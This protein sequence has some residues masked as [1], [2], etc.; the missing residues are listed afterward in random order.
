MLGMTGLLGLVS[1]ALL[2]LRGLRVSR[3]CR[4]LLD[5]RALRALTPLCR[6]L[7]GLLVLTALPALLV[8][9]GL[10]GVRS[11]TRNADPTVGGLSHGLTGPP[12]T[13]ANAALI[14]HPR[15]ELRHDLAC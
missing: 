3:A 4:D 15:L 9:P 13:Q 11:R 7:L 1:R 14:L 10:M 5:L 2:V 12:L 6:V 8:R